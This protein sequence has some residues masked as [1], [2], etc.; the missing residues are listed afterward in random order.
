MAL[1]DVAVEARRLLP[2]EVPGSDNP[3]EIRHWHAVYTELWEGCLEICDGLDPP[4]RSSC[5]P[6]LAGS[7]RGWTIGRNGAITFSAANLARSSTSN[8]PRPSAA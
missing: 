3:D 4:R 7:K 6:V 1:G 5:C 2:G 8:R